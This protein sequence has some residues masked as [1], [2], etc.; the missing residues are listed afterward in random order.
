MATQIQL[1][2]S[3]TAHKR[4]TP[5]G[6]SAGEVLVNDNSASP[7]LF[8]KDSDGAL[9]KAGPVHI[10]S[11]A[12]N[13]SP[14]GQSGVQKGEQW[15][16]TGVTPNKLKV[17]DGTQWVSTTP[18]VPEGGQGAILQN[19]QTYDA[20]VTLTGSYNGF[21]VGPVAVGTGVTVTVSAGATWHII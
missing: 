16:D 1:K 14:A 8:F 18:T 3:S 11:S 17:Y 12:P 19:Q 6:M 10:S 20:D 9:V 2:R 21:S 13:S 4:P 7:G 15:L 5:S